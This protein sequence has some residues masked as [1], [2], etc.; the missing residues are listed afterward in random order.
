MAAAPRSWLVTGA[1]GFI[2]SGLVEALLSADQQVVG[3]DNF[4]TGKRTNL[5]DVRARVGEGRWRQ[6]IST[7]G[8]SGT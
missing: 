3:L 2:G 5:E 1:A 8:T 6:F 4:S 7:R